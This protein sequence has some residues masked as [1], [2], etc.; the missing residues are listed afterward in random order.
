[1]AG[2]EL[3]WCRKPKLLKSFQPQQAILDD[4][5]K[6]DCLFFGQVIYYLKM[7]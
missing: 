1:M 4:S 7:N 2:K 5:I 3:A 6:Q